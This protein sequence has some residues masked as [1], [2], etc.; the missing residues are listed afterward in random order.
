M[1]WPNMSAGCG[2]GIARRALWGALALAA[3][4]AACVQP[5]AAAIRFERLGALKS[6]FEATPGVSVERDCGFSRVLPGDPHQALWVFCDSVV[7]RLGSLDYL[8]GSSAARGPYDVGRAPTALDEVPTPPRVQPPAAPEPFLPAPQ[9]VRRADGRFCPPSRSHY[10]VAWTMGLAAAPGSRRI[11]VPYVAY[12]VEPT[13]RPPFR[14]ARFGYAEYDPATSAMTD[15]PA[16]FRGAP[17]S[18]LR[19]LGSPVVRP[20][21]LYVFASSCGR[22]DFGACTRGR[23]VVARVALGRRPAEARPWLLAHRYRYW[24]GRAFAGRRT[25]QARSILRRAAPNA[26]TVEDVPAKRRLV[27]LE[28]LGL[29]GELRVYVARR[30]QGPWR[31][32]GTG[33]LP[34]CDAVRGTQSFCRA[35]TP[36]SELSTR[37]R[38]VISYFDPNRTE[39]RL[40]AMRW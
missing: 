38:L 14:A 4:P 5:A 9:G 33:R 12:C 21:S 31:V 27:L 23:V 28:N 36:H 3:V 25:A 19:A 1:E 17:L 18:D 30:P 8:L 34:S 6:T 40:V 7:R 20:G 15:F 22:R 26:V 35:I 39:L 16:V 32:I 2:A 11:L 13:T 10:P 37:R 24:N 29:N